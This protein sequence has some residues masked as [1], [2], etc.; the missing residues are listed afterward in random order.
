MYS[1]LFSLNCSFLHQGEPGYPGRK[2]MKGDKGS[3]GG[4][5]RPGVNGSPGEKGVTGYPGPPG[6]S[7]VHTHTRTNTLLHAPMQYTKFLPCVKA[8]TFIQATVHVAE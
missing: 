8:I 1:I 5:G 6:K 7:S 4:A 2:G 3:S